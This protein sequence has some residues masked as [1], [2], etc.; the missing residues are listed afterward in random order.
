MER[1]AGSDRH[2]QRLFCQTSP[3]EMP[4]LLVPVVARRLKLA[5]P[6]KRCGLRGE[7]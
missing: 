5:L 2:R 7:E 1:T 4:D 3:E 6:A